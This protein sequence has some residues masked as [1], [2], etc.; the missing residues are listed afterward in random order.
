M[1]ICIIVRFCTK[2]ESPF[3]YYCFMTF[4]FIT[5]IFHVS[6]L[7]IYNAIC[8]DSVLVCYRTA[9]LHFTILLPMA[10]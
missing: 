8:S 2:A 1:Y 6:E 10:V 5:R 4:F 3:V 9:I 7:L